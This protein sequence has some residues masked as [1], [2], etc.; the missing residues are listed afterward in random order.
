[1]RARLR[2]DGWTDGFLDLFSSRHPNLDSHELVW[3]CNYL[4]CATSWHQFPFPCQ[5][6]SIPTSLHFP[7]KFK[8]ILNFL[9]SPPTVVCGSHW[10]KKKKKK[11][12]KLCKIWH[13]HRDLSSFISENVV[14][15]RKCI[16][17]AVM[18]LKNLVQFSIK[19]WLH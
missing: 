3:Q 4:F 1:M 18:S 17:S 9:L 10:P 11:S 6:L 13:L 19:V 15:K 8:R 12:I 7:R 2:N 16:T 14:V 5:T